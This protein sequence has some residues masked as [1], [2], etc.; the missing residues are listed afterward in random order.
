MWFAVDVVGV[1][2]VLPGFGRQIRVT[3]HTGA[4]AD[5]LA[6]SGPPALSPEGV[7]LWVGCTGGLHGGVEV[8]WG[9][10]GSDGVLACCINI[11]P[12]DL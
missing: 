2:G 12:Y 11:K 5:L 9:G 1:C 6:G 4:L 3:A 8:G 10:V 7:G